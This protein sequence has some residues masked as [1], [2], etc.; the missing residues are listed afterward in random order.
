MAWLQKRGGVWW[1]GWR[2]DGRQVR[3]SLRTSDKCFA[4]AEL[5]RV[6]SIA[7]TAN[8][9]AVT[10]DYIEAM[11]GRAPAKKPTLVEFL[12]AWLAESEADTTAGTTAKYRQVILEFTAAVNAD[13]LP[14]RVDDVTPEQIAQFLADIHAFICPFDGRKAISMLVC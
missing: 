14:M 3:K 8:S 10:A 11:T 13:S 1:I 2:H 12:N 5:D 9:N 4:K 7:V 6:N